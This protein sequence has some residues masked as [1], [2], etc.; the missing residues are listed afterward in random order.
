[1]EDLAAGRSAAN[2]DG[3]IF[4]AFNNPTSR[5][6]L[7]R[8]VLEVLEDRTTRG[9]A[10]P[11]QGSP[12]RVVAGTRQAESEHQEHD[13]YF[14]VIRGDGE[15]AVGFVAGLVLA[16]LS[17]YEDCL[18]M[19][20]TL[21]DDADWALLFAGLQTVLAAPYGAAP[22]LRPSLSG[23]GDEYD[24]A[25]RW[26]VGHQ[27]FFALIQ[28]AV[29]GLNCFASA[30]EKGSS[31]EAARGL[32]MAA[33]FLR[34]SASAMKFTSDFSPEDYELT[35]R[36][37]MAPPIVRA[38]FSG[39]QTRDHA[40]LVKLFGSLTPVLRSAVA[41]EGHRDFVDALASAYA[42][43]ELICARFRGD[44]LPSL[45]MAAASSGRTRRTGVEVIRELLHA[46]LALIDPP[47]DR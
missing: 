34:S 5:A 30:A 24:P 36:P 23:W 11:S 18:R 4:E 45:R 25:R 44:I 46:R 39:L 21:L 27:L 9:N 43:H 3:S 35:V 1:M 10:L 17:A 6:L 41:S 22:P 13:R 31:A 7:R 38:G 16:H 28:G 33:A 8:R 15:A 40:H 20:L 26:L 2:I 19:G 12:S 37:A 32:A 42:A 47:S 14:A 29:V